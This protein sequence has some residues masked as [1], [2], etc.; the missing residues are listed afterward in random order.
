M[1]AGVNSFPV[2]HVQDDVDL[3]LGALQR[4][5]AGAGLHDPA[6]TL[7][8]TREGP[9]TL[10]G[11]LWSGLRIQRSLQAGPVRWGV[12]FMTRPSRRVLPR[13]SVYAVVGGSCGRGASRLSRARKC[14]VWSPPRHRGSP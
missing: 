5:N 2:R 12:A 4:R 3:L 1:T 10:P 13:S 7:V 8:E 11:Q 9:P 14:L 6:L